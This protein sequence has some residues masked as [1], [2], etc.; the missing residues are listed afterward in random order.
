MTET[1]TGSP[2]ARL[3]EARKQIRIALDNAGPMERNRI[4]QEVTDALTGIDGAVVKET[5]L[6]S[7]GRAYFGSDMEGVA[8][9]AVFLPYNQTVGVATGEEGEDA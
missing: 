6:Q 1:E 4:I 3:G 7:Q 2:L 5:D 8:G 9:M